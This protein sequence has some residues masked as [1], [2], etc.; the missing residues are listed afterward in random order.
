MYNLISFNN[1]GCLHH[2][3]VGSPLGSLTHLQRIFHFFI[4]IVYQLDLCIE[5]ANIKALKLMTAFELINF[6]AVSR[7]EFGP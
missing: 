7:L 6:F 5:Y 3:Q 1:I 4:I 2:I